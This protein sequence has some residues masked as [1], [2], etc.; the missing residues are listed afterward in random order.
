M[1]YCTYIH[2]NLIDGVTLSLSHSVET[3]S[4]MFK[5]FLSFSRSDA[6]MKVLAGYTKG[7]S[8]KDTLSCTGNAIQLN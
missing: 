4:G 6:V 1:Y 2:D 8:L 5:K 7:I 3:H